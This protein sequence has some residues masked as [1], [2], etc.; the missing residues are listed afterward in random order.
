MT[1]PLGH[2]LTLPCGLVLPNRIA[3]AALSEFMADSDGVPSEH[4]ISLYRRWGEGGAGL[5]ITGNVMVDPRYIEAPG[6]VA[7]NG[8]LSKLARRRGPRPRSSFLRLRRSS[9]YSSP[10]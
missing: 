2:A 8:K 10:S 3:K 4:M 1:T 6:N 9:I 7:L 5:V